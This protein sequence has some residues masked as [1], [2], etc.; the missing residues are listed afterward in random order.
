ML[1]DSFIIKKKCLL[2]LKNHNK[3]NDVLTIIRWEK[4]IIII[5][6]E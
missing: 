2:K 6:R 5:V 1:F 3:K 4:M